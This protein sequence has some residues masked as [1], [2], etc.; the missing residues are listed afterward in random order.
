MGQPVCV[1]GCAFLQSW[2]SQLGVLACQWGSIFPSVK[3]STGYDS[4]ILI[5]QA[6]NEQQHAK[7]EAQQSESSE[8][9]SRAV[10]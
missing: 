6:K 8:S 3:N 1:S 7:T 4:K 9:H 10:P 5:I 2:G